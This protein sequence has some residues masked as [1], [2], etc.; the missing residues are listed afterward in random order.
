MKKIALISEW[1]ASSAL[2]GANQS[3]VE[4]LYE[5]YLDNLKLLTKVG[6]KF[7][8]LFQ[9]RNALVSLIQKSVIILNV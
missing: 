7:S 1:L 6:N 8:I 5:D 4:D 2:G 9:N 3:Y